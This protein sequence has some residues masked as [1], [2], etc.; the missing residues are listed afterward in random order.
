MEIEFL[1][2]YN[3]IMQIGDLAIRGGVITIT[4]RHHEE[5]GIL[6]PLDRKENVF[7]L[8]S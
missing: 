8:C 7:R 1:T 6:K 5:L 3:S 4:I 2:E